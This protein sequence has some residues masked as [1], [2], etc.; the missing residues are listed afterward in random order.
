MVPVQLFVLEDKIRDDGED[1][2]RDSLLYHLQ[3]H[4]IKGSAVLDIAD[5]V[6]RHL[7]TVLKEGDRPREGDHQI[8]GPV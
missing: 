8:K 2:Q 4:K 3:L 6:G 5:T 7:T 1:H